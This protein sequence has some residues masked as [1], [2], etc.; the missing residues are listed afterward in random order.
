MNFRKLILSLFCVLFAIQ[1]QAQTVQTYEKQPDGSYRKKVIQVEEDTTAFSSDEV[2]ADWFSKID[3]TA[4]AENRRWLEAFNLKLEYNQIIRDQQTNEPDTSYIQYN[5]RHNDTYSYESLYRDSTTNQIVY[6]S[7]LTVGDTVYNVQLFQN[8]AGTQLIRIE[9]LTGN[10]AATFIRSDK[11]IRLGNN[12]K[13][14]PQL[15]AWV[16]L[17]KIAD[18]GRVAVFWAISE[19]KRVVLRIKKR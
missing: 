2:I 7:R 5:K 12:V 15:N 13:P 16:D 6:D 11:I 1:L 18:N 17:Q 14:A 3:A 4:N 9:E 19:G 10:L 8:N